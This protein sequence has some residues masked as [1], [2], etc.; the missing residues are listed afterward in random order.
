MVRGVATK[1]QKTNAVMG[2][3]PPVLHLPSLAGTWIT[4]RLITILKSYIEHNEHTNHKS[5]A[6][7]SA[8]IQ[9]KHS[10]TTALHSIIDPIIPSF[11]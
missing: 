3:I 6:L 4:V 2:T 1:A 11:N 8:Q 7:S 5:S 10:I 9:N